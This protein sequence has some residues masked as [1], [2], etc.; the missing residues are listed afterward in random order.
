MGYLCSSALMSYDQCSEKMM[1]W[2]GGRG[3]VEEIDFLF[4]RADETG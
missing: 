1:L 2:K 4:F 3:R